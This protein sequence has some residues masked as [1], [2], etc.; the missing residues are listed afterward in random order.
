[1]CSSPS[2]YVKLIQLKGFIIARILP[3]K[4]IKFREM[5]DLI[6]FYMYKY[7]KVQ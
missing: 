7:E 3:G 4:R 1:M 6:N 5:Y 2:V